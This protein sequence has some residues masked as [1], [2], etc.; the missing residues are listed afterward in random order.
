MQFTARFALPRLDE[1]RAVAALRGE[2]REQAAARWQ[3]PD[4]STLE[5]SGPVEVAG[6]SGRVWYRWA[7][8][9]EATT[10]LRL[11]G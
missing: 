8:T 1:S 7:A 5:V 9:V 6:A 11:P 2:L 10:S 4:W 3:V